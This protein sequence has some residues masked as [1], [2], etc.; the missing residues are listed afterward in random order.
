MDIPLTQAAQPLPQTLLSL[1]PRQARQLLR[2]ISAALAQREAHLH[3]HGTA[4]P[5]GSSSSS[6]NGHNG[7]SRDAGERPGVGA[8]STALPT[9]TDE[10]LDDTA[11]HSSIPVVV[12]GD[13]NTV[14]S[15]ATCQ[16]SKHLC[17]HGRARTCTHN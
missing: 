4:G 7:H 5:G 11:C 6:S 13:F 12:T 10:S 14:P 16:V 9:T 3:P 8:Q 1:A 2:C 15:S 17:T